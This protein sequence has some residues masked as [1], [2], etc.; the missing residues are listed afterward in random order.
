M[1]AG[2]IIFKR[3]ELATEKELAAI[4]RAL[5]EVKEFEQQPTKPEK[6]DLLSR[7]LRANAGSVFGNLRRHDHELAYV[8]IL[9]DVLEKAANAAGWST[10]KYPL[11]TDPLRVEDYIIKAF[12]FA[13][14]KESATT[15]QLKKAE[16]DAARELT[17]TPSPS[18]G[19][20]VSGTAARVAVIAAQTLL[21]TNPYVLTAS[22]VAAVGFGVAWI[23]GPAMRRV[24]PAVLVLIQIR[25]RVEAEASLRGAA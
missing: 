9:E 14:T 18:A 22:A 17:A 12:A 15:E 24:T 11:E 10:P 3:L 20:S 23:A 16:E 7:E 2:D 5:D 6:I 8:R 19:A 13:L 21:R 4:A 25:H 1:P